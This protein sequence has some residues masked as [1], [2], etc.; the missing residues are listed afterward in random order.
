MTSIHD[1][2]ALAGVSTATVSRALRGVDRVSGPT[3][4]RVLLAAAELHYVASPAAA[5]LASGRTGVVG[6]VVPFL[7]RWF[8]SQV[9]DGVE[10]RLRECDLHVLLF[11]VGTG[12][13]RSVLLDLERLNKRLDALLVVSCDLR[14]DEVAMLGRLGVPVATVGVDVAGWDLVRIDDIAT[15][16]DAMTHL[17]DLGHRRVAFLGGDQRAD[18][19]VATSIDRARGVARA[20]HRQGL[21]ADAGGM[22]VA[23]W[24]VLGGM[25]AVDGLLDRVDPPTAV[26][27]A[28]DEMAMGVLHELR[29]RGV[30]VPE[31]ISVMGIDGHE[32]SVTHDLTT[33]VQPVGELGETAAQLVV[34]V[35][36]SP[37]LLGSPQRLRRVKTLPTM[38]RRGGTTGPV[39]TPAVAA[40]G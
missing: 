34:D 6:V 26:L 38:L 33:M 37:S 11:N 19:H 22:Q 2:A 4:D 13:H 9:L 20:L 18:V 27:A 8:F 1:V 28:S 12:S 39:C 40:L 15:A 10:R 29:R 21:P 24:T 31:Q 35:L 36:R 30:Q 3:R 17:L 16:D 5:S 14:P 32:V 25:A 23:D 7:S